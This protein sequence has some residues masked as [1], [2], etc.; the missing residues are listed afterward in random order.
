MAASRPRPLPGPQPVLNPAHPDHPL[1]PPPRRTRPGRGDRHGD[2]PISFTAII[3]I[4]G[5]AALGLFLLNDRASLTD[6]TKAGINLVVVAAVVLW[7]LLALD[8]FA[9]LNV[10]GLSP[11]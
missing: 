2:P 6:R 10:A 8:V 1:T 3:L 4:L 11:G 9:G 7:L 5:A